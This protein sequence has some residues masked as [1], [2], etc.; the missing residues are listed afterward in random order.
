MIFGN[1]VTSIHI[2]PMFD[3]DFG[4][5]TL[6]NRHSYLYNLKKCITFAQVFLVAILGRLQYILFNS[7]ASPLLINLRWPI[8]GKYWLGFR[9]GVT[10][11]L[12]YGGRVP[13]F[14]L[15]AIIE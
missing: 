11:G 7:S 8:N 13:T 2:V 12:L 14:G 6:H 4:S 9:R 10:D 3:K 15:Y 1:F 5:P